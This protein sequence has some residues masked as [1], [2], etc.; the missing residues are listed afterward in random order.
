M[1]D[2][3]SVEGSREIKSKT[4]KAVRAGKNKQK[5]MSN[6]ERTG[7]FIITYTFKEE[8]SSEKEKFIEIITDRLK[9][10]KAPDQSTYFRLDRIQNRPEFIQEIR[11]SIENIHLDSDEHITGYYSGCSYVTNAIYKVILK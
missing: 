9:F 4:C 5:I 6:R 7:Y 3:N 10:V 2:N 8:H 11:K 1:S